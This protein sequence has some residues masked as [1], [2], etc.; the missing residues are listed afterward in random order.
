MLFLT[1]FVRTA[2]FQPLLQRQQKPAAVKQKIH[3]RRKRNIVSKN[4]QMLV[5]DRP[6]KEGN[7]FIADGE[8]I[9]GN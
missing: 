8:L 9:R 2:S 1:C 6:V 7:K 4:L 3:E 5:S